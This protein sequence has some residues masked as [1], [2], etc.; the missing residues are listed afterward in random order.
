MAFTKL[1]LELDYRL[2]GR[3]VAPQEHQMPYITLRIHLIDLTSDD[4]HDMQLDSKH[5]P[6]PAVVD[7]RSSSFSI[8]LE[9]EL[10]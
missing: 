2:T 3:L 7:R 4:M 6:T 8:P 10:A 1:C 5:V 9:D